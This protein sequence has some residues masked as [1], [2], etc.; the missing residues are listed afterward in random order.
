M[1][2]YANSCKFYIGYSHRLSIYI[3]GMP[4]YGVIIGGGRSEWLGGTWRALL[5][6]L[7]PFPL[8]PFLCKSYL[9]LLMFG[10]KFDHVTPDQ[11]RRPRSQ[12]DVTPAKMY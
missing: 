3:Q 6:P 12:H 4:E 1:T 11:H 7:A 5:L 9:I 2:V 8:S 10:T